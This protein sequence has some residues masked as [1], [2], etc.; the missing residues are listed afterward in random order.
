[1]GTIKRDKLIMI[2]IMLLLGFGIG[3]LIVSQFYSGL[4]A[5]RS[6]DPLKPT[7]ELKS[8][9]ENLAIAQQELKDRVEDLQSEIAAK[10]E[11]L[12]N[13]QKE[14]SQLL[15]EIDYY[16]TELGMS[17]A[18][19]EGIII[20][21]GDATD[22]SNIDEVAMAISH[23]TDLLDLVNVLWQEGTEAITINNERIVSTT[24]I[25]CVGNNILINNTPKGAPFTI[26]AIGDRA[27]LLGAIKDED[28]LLELYSRSKKYGLSLTAVE[29]AL[30]MPAYSGGFDTE[31]LSLVTTIE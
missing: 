17:R 27:R 28:R 6:P 20:N 7:L 18:N 25:V 5:L 2:I 15:D 21:L 22:A 8:T 1:M 30:D 19:G 10:E 23:S 9:Q 4:R 24:A 3:F 31:Y 29:A 13:T 12:K 16:K 26:A 14:S 11:T